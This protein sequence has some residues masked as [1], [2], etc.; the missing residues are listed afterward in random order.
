MHSLFTLAINLSV[1]ISHDAPVGITES[2]F[3][4]KKS[5]KCYLLGRAPW[6]RSLPYNLVIQVLMVWGFTL[7]LSEMGPYGL[8]LY[9]RT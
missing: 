7:E 4:G 1:F 2:I 3:K 9:T 6:S 8:G 5:A